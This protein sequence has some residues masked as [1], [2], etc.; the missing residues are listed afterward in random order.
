MSFA[1]KFKKK[2]KKKSSLFLLSSIPPF[3]F[4][5]ILFDKNLS[6]LPSIISPTHHL[7]ETFCFPIHNTCFEHSSCPHRKPK[8]RKETNFLC[9]NLDFG[10]KKGKWNLGG[11][12]VGVK[13]KGRVSQVRVGKQPR[14]P[15]R[16]KKIIRMYCV[17]RFGRI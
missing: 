10:K 14:S 7:L 1:C 3:V 9:R 17:Q 13:S 15:S 12:C 4:I 5:C 6:F 2:T 8:T 11:K 16:C